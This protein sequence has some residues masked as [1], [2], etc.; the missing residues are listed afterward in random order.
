MVK[1]AHTECQ[2]NAKHKIDWRNE[3]ELGEFLTRK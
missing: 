2:G 3:K 1:T